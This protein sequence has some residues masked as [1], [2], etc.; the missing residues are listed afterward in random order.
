[1]G[2]MVQVSRDH[3]LESLQARLIDLRT[4][5]EGDLA[6]V[7]EQLAS[8]DRHPTPMHYSAHHLIAGG[9]KRIRPMC[10]ALAARLGS[11]FDAA[12][13]DLAV[14]AELIH[15][16]TLLHDDVVDVGDMRRDSPTARVVFGNAA[17]VYA[18]DWLLVEA[19]MRVR[20][21]GNL[22]LLD[23]G[24]GVLSQMLEAEA[25]Q[26]ARRGKV[27]VSI[28]DYLQVVQG[29]TASLF[30]WALYAGARAGGL[31]DEQANRLESFGGALGVAFQVIDDVLDIDGSAV[32]I[33]KT[34][35][36][37]VRE[38]KI[39]YPLIV[40]MNEEPS[41]RAWMAERAPVGGQGNGE[42]SG[43]LS[44]ED[45]D[46]LRV[47]LGQTSATRAART[48]AEQLIGRATAELHAFPPSHATRALFAVAD[49]VIHRGR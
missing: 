1:M 34:M 2:T 3:D 38:G 46:Y 45:A 42:G 23:R 37:D 4:F 13:R 29:K 40:A 47:M 7:E 11:G 44:D 9:G 16:A 12:A 49:A 8:I 17:S 5:L 28:D 48:Y 6:Q 24:L 41:L 31:T 22:D 10:V 43:E 19:L 25:L 32:G 39:T 27:D 14:A 35:L 21:A 15:S 20:R 36:Q 33:G 18:G 30:R 26:L